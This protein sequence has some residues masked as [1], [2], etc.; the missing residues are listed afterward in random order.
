MFLLSFDKFF[1]ILLFYCFHGSYKGGFSMK[2]IRAKP[3]LTKFITVM[4]YRLLII[5]AAAAYNI[6]GLPGFLHAA[7]DQAG[8]Q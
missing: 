2:F 5:R 7:V 1:V 8:V 4:R 3:A 6:H